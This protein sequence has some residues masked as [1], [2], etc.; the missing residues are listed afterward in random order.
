[1][2]TK[3]DIVSTLRC[4]RDVCEAEGA[5]YDVRPNHLLVAAMAVTMITDQEFEAAV[6]AVQITYGEVK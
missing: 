2:A 6:E 3:E 4:M 5:S 1:M